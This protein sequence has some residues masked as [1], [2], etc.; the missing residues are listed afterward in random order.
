MRRLHSTKFVCCHHA[1]LFLYFIESILI[2]QLKSTIF[3][4]L[5]Q[6]SKKI[7]KLRTLNTNL[8]KMLLSD[9]KITLKK[10]ADT[11]YAAPGINHNF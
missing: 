10:I 9:E 4:K 1:H 3:D 8:M 2:S 11:V 6:K 5:N 7:I